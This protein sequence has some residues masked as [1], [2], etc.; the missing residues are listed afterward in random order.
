MH[1]L[2]DIA[3]DPTSRVVER[4]RERTVLE[5]SRGGIVI[6]VVTD[7]LDIITGFPVR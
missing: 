3:T 6:R 2:S 1:E 4:Q 7:G 5:G